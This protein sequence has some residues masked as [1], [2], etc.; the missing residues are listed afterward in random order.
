MEHMLT[1]RRS[2]TGVK[3]DPVHRHIE[4]T[5]CLC[6]WKREGTEMACHFPVDHGVCL[7]DDQ[8]KDSHSLCP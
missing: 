8:T 7:L 2:L 1:K 3:L 6:E 5:R 4:R